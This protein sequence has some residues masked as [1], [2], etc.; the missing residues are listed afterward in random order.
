MAHLDS[1]HEIVTTENYK[2]LQ[3]I[4]D[5]NIPN[6][7]PYQIREY[8]KSGKIAMTGSIGSRIGDTK[9]GTFVYFY[10]NGKRKSVLNYEQ[11]ELLRVYY[12]FYE[13]GEKKLEGEWIDNKKNVIPSIN[14]KNYWNENGVQTIK[15]GT[16]F[17][18]ESYFTGNFPYW[19]KERDFGQGK[20]VNNLKDSIWTGNKT[21]SKISY[22]ETYKNGILISG[23]LIDAL[24]ESHPYT[25]LEIAPVPKKGM[26]DFYKFI[27]RNYK[28]PEI[29]GL[30]GKIFIKFTVEK[31]GT[32]VE[33]KILRDLGFGTGDEAIRVLMKYGNWV[34]GEIRGVK[35]K[36]TFSIPIAIQSAN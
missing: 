15:D 3:V 23:V 27:G 35:V 1:L 8:Y 34:P 28:T 13:N 7:E 18:K 11:N 22:S 5:Y 14:I 9:I 17:F 6:K 24:L 29:K 30:S 20:I 10:E 32:I 31:D 36:C 19:F 4:K 33:T 21:K 12:E 2:Y 16:G 25:E 26:K